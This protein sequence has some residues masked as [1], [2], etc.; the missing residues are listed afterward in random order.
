MNHNKD[1]ALIMHEHTSQDAAFRR[2]RDRCRRPE[3]VGTEP[4]SDKSRRV[5]DSLSSR[6]QKK[7]TH[8]QRRKKPAAS[9]KQQPLLGLLL[10]TMMRNINHNASSKASTHIPTSAPLLLL[11]HQTAGQ[12]HKFAQR[13]I[14]QLSF[15]LLCHFCVCDQRRHSP[16]RGHLCV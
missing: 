2:G 6:L 16:V 13:R 3:Q 1:E 10:L 9:L 11:R 14:F 8:R 15:L 5:S 7:Q 12:T 4:A